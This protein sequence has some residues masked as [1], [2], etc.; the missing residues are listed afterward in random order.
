MSEPIRLGGVPEHVNLPWHQALAG[1]GFPDAGIQWTDMPGG[2]GQMMQALADGEL[3]AAVVLTE[4]AIA[5]IVGGSPARV[6]RVFVTSPLH[7]GVHV[8]GG[9][10]L[11]E[12]ALGP[13]HR[14]AVSRLGSGSH[15]MAHVLADRLGFEVDDDRFVVVGDVD[16]ARAALANDE[17]DVFLWDRFMTAPLVDRG[18]FARIGVQPTPWPAFV[19]AVHEDLLAGG[20][21]V[22]LAAGGGNNNRGNSITEVVAASGGDF[23]GNHQD[24]DM[25]LNAVLAADLADALDD[26]ALDATVFAPKDAAFVRLAK[27]LGYS[28]NDEA[29]AFDAIVSFLT[30]AGGGDPIPLLTDILLYH[31]SPGEKTIYRVASVNS[32]P[33]LQGE[34]I[35]V[36]GLR[37]VDADPDLKNPAIVRP[38][39]IRAE[40]GT[41][42]P[43]NRVLLPIDA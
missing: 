34:R 38:F 26:P 13:E 28:G 37:L 1:D 31:V 43:L 18:E 11:T 24:Y 5:A 21:S 40:N 36:D 14:F 9:S 42:L 39:Q 22:A 7:W 32:V 35:G 23:D 8:A 16:G 20:R 6:V 15:L 17:A 12:D 41:I 19:I 33:T 30:T 27:D 2:T 10:A 3:D 4:G 25:L 29:G